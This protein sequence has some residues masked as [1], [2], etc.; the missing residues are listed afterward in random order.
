MTATITNSGKSDQIVYDNKMRPRRIAAGRSLDLEL[1][2][3][4]VRQLQRRQKR[5]G[6][7]LLGQDGLDF[8][9][10]KEQAPSGPDVPP[11]QDSAEN[12]LRDFADDNI[13]YSGLL[14]RSRQLLGN[15]GAG[16][17]KQSDLLEQ[18][19]QRVREEKARE[20]E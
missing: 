17:P 9:K 12:I 18:L 1:S 15:L 8:L 3:E 10:R 5:G 2:D 4:S 11:A 13:K 19:R 7:L 14:S 20:E 16:Q 6:T